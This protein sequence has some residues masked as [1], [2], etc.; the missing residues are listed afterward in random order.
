[1]KTSP[2]H[3]IHTSQGPDVLVRMN[4]NHPQLFHQAYQLHVGTL[5]EAFAGFNTKGGFVQ[6]RVKALDPIMI[7][8]E[9]HNIYVEVAD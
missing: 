5:V 3:K 2:V 9:K 4:P 7:F 6:W 8:D 1:M